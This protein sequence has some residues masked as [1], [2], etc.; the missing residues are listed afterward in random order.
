MGYRIRVKPNH[1]TGVMYIE[2]Q[3]FTREWK[4]IGKKPKNIKKYLKWVE[5][6]KYDGRKQG[7]KEDEVKEAQI[8]KGE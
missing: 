8:E 3:K 2:G 5:I 1:P 4:T 7:A 6:E